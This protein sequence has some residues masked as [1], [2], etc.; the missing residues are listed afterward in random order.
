MNTKQLSRVLSLPCL[1]A[2]SAFAF[3]CAEKDG[4]AYWPVPHD[5]AGS[6]ETFTVPDIDL[7]EPGTFCSRP[8]LKVESCGPLCDLPRPP[9]D[10]ADAD[11]DGACD[12]QDNCP[13]LYNAL[14]H[15]EDGDGVGDRCDPTCTLIRRESSGSEVLDTMIASDKPDTVF[16]DG[17]VAFTGYANGEQ[18]RTLLRFDLAAVPERAEV[19]SSSLTLYHQGTSPELVIAHLVTAPWS[20]KDATWSSFG[21]SYAEGALASFFTS[22]GAVTVDLTQ[23]VQAWLSGEW[24]NDGILLEQQAGLQT[25]FR[26][27]EG[28]LGDRPSLEVCWVTREEP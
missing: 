7:C 9:G 3:G 16:G 26:T 22:G 2:L 25:T 6:D 12:A 28:Q 11:A 1:A 20:E 14:Q 8:V 18:R 13:D 23:V 24:D 19:W 5:E 10:C 17:D 4:V 15:D 21:E 27:S